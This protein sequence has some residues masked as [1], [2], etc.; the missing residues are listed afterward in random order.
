VTKFIEEPRDRAPVA[1]FAYNRPDKVAS[2]M[3]NL[4]ACRGFSESPV[5]VFVDGPR[6][7]ADDPAVNAVRRFVEKIAAPN[8]SFTF[9][10]SN[11]GLRNSIFTGVTEMISEYGRTIV[12][13]DDLILSPMSLDYFNEAL[14]KYAAEMRVWSIAGYN[15]DVPELRHSG[16]ALSLPFTHPWGW[17]TWARAWNRFDLDSRPDSHELNSR[18]FQCAFDMN[19]IYPFTKQLK[20]SI[21]GRVNSWSVHWYYT[22]FRH[23]GVSIFPPRRVVD[24][25]GLNAGTHGGARNPS[26]LLIRRPD[27]LAEM[28]EFCEPDFIDY[29]AMDALRRCREL[30][31]RRY[32]AHVGTAKRAVTRKGTS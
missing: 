29:T 7:D 9:H 14:N 28:P 22:V 4:Q 31:V 3:S 10:E 8:V 16:K 27:L 32:I 26:N 13:E 19:G 20:N 30:H 21:S 25:N 18:S 23:G 11:L 12:L 24:N 2:L 1:V 17:A 15:Y 5:R 6:N